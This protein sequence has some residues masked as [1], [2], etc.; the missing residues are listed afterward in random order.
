MNRFTLSLLICFFAFSH[1][2]LAQK[3]NKPLDIIIT[4]AR[5]IDG[6]GNPWFKGEI[7]IRDGAIVFVGKSNGQKAKRIIDAKNQVVAPGFIDVHAHAEGS[8]QARPIAQN[9]IYDGVTTIVTGNCGGSA[10]DLGD[11]F[12][13]IEK[14]KTSINVASLVGH[15][16]VRTAVLGTV[17][18]APS[19]EEQKQMEALV[20]QAM[21]EGAVGLSTGLIYIPGTFAK[22][23]EVVG[24]AK[25]AAKYNGV[26]ASHI[27]KEDHEVFD[28]IDEA[29]NIGK[30]ANIP[31]QISHFKITGKNSWG[32]SDK[33]IEMVNNYRKEGIDVTVDQY[34]YTASSTRL[35]V[36]VPSWTLS[37]GN[38][39]F[40]IRIDNP[41]MKAQIVKEMKAML[42][43]TGFPDFSYAVI[44][45]SPWD[46]NHNG[47]NISEVNQMNGREATIDE[48]IETIIEMV[49]KG[50]RVQMV[51]HKMG[52]EDVQRIMKFPLSMVARDAGIPNFGAG[53]PHPR[54]YGSCG[55]V[56]GHYV[57]E[58]G[59]LTL[60][61]AIR[62]ITSLPAQ[63]FQFND[64]GL[65]QP[66]KAADL[67][68]FDPE[69]IR[70][71]AT[72]KKSH[73]YTKGMSYVLVNGTVVVDEGEHNGKR[74]GVV[75]RGN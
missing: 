56:L 62:K 48:E 53:N 67:V 42:A 9:F 26:Y 16:T 46:K 4:N 60:E 33:M 44:A 28:A 17:N 39:S 8:I 64:R 75:L 49:R 54:S 58:L 74:P 59:V 73:D 35:S 25:S 30:E 43:E 63:R 50:R 71:E 15:N 3:K 12:D 68:I 57:R 18:R 1:L 24:L 10:K 38:D 36:L 45:Y 41:E 14:K 27:R 51:Y 13:Q 61:D 52:E 31:V 37:G 55:R 32:Q 40:N 2:L 66:G 29:V 19:A 69:E 7:G 21:E 47:K 23:E 6:T 65:I 72:F 22:T 11:F 34:P 70:S 20:A 5:I